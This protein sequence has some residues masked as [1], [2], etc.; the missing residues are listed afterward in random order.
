[1]GD[2]SRIMESLTIIEGKL[3]RIERSA[4]MQ[5]VWSIGFAAVVGSVG[6]LQF[7]R[8]FSLAAFF[9]GLAIMLLSPYARK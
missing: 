8:V 4:Q 3:D 5:W 6:L 2:N 9:L 7:N 1:V